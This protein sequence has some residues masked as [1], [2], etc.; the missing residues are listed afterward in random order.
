MVGYMEDG[1][2]YYIHLV[3][4]RIV[5]FKWVL[6]VYNPTPKVAPKGVGPMVVLSSRVCRMDLTNAVVIL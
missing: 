1:K 5:L 4:G 2:G 3:I 6:V